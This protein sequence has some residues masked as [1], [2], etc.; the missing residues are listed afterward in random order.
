MGNDINS[1]NDRLVGTA[2]RDKALPIMPKTSLK[3]PSSAITGAAEGDTQNF[4][5]ASDYEKKN[6]S[7]ATRAANSSLSSPGVVEMY[8]AVARYEA[9]TPT[10]PAALSGAVA[11]FRRNLENQK[12]GTE[13][14]AELNT[15]EENGNQRLSFDP[16]IIYNKAIASAHKDFYD[17]YP[18][19]A[20]Q[21]HV[22]EE[23][24]PSNPGHRF[25][26]PSVQRSSA[27][28]QGPGI[29][30]MAARNA[31]GIVDNLHDGGVAEKQP[32]HTRRDDKKKSKQQ[33]ERVAGRHF[34][35]GTL[36]PGKD[37]TTA[38]GSFNGALKQASERDPEYGPMTA[39]E[40][41]KAE[42]AARKIDKEMKKQQKPEQG[43]WRFGKGDRMKALPFSWQRKQR[44]NP[45]P[46]PD[47][48]ASLPAQEK[49]LD[50]EGDEGKEL[51]RKQIDEE[52]VLEA[53]SD[54]DDDNGGK[55]DDDCER[56]RRRRSRDDDSD[57]YRTL[58]PSPIEEYRDGVLYLHPLRLRRACSPVSFVNSHNS[59]DT[60]EVKKG[61]LES[62]TRINSR[63]QEA[64]GVSVKSWGEEPTR[65][66]SHST[67]ETTM[68][69][70]EVEETVTHRTQ[71]SP[72]HLPHRMILW[73]D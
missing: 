16:S 42:K 27:I 41:Q 37:K 59:Y 15:C 52:K 60:E 67:S 10:N 34:E 38:P 62:S 8:N 45:T 1:F 13:E 3:L 29:R 73:D 50:K 43:R 7:A 20:T 54:D 9:H 40:T 4:T 56:Q 53:D 65:V 64:D 22:G 44:D 14:E 32:N 51:D 72:S 23:V 63:P 24:A 46:W 19:P 33:S 5:S 28:M 36:R 61:E 26:D 49:A 11:A 2:N 70:S 55:K 69:L 47:W 35:A 71:R 57:E 18:T 31:R 17:T 39:K 21:D 25:N 30:Y 48:E 12:K 58:S 66:I 6:R 68:S